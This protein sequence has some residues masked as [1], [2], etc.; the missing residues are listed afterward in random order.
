M[1]TVRMIVE[2]TTK[3]D[4]IF[5]VNKE[6]NGRIVKSIAFRRDGLVGVNNGLPCGANYLITLEH[7]VNDKDIVY[8]VFPYDAIGDILY[9]EAEKLDESPS[10]TA[11]KKL[12]RG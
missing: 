12:K 9:I 7:P 10:E 4:V 1:T 6:Y 2:I 5:E 3:K 8:K 11:T